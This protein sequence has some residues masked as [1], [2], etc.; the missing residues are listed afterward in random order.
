MIGDIAGL[1]IG[2]AAGG[3]PRCP[4]SAAASSRAGRGRAPARHASSSASSPSPA[5][6]RTEALLF[7]IVLEQGYEVRLVL[8]DQDEGFERRIHGFVRSKAWLLTLQFRLRLRRHDREAAFVAFWPFRCQRMTDHQKMDGL[9]DV[10][11]MVADALDVLGDEQEMRAGRDI[12]RIFHHVG[13]ELR[14]TGWCRDRPFPRRGATPHRLVHVA[15][16][17]GV[18]HFLHDLLDQPAHARTAPTPADGGQLGQRD[19]RAWRC[20]LA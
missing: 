18:E 15:L 10:G 4:T 7:E 16:D 17:E 12:A 8:D 11:R 5:D 2:A 13:Q 9:G 3:R 20:C 14:G 6:E 19:R 1:R